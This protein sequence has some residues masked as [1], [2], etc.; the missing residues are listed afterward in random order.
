MGILALLAACAR[1]AALDVAVTTTVEASGLL[2]RLAPAFE[3]SVGVKLRAVVAGTGQALKLLEKGDVE[4]TLTHD[5]LAEEELA[6]RGVAQRMPVMW[7]EFIFVGPAADPAGVRGRPVEE[8][9]RA[10]A[11]GGHPF[12]SRGDDSGTHRLERKLWS[13]AGAEPARP[14]YR[15]TG[16]GMGE[17]LV[18][19]SQ[20]LAYTM[21]DSATLA[22]F[23]ARTGL[24]PLV[25]GDP[26]LVNH[27]GV[28]WRTPRGK[29]F[30]DWLRTP[31][32][33]AL[34]RPLFEPAP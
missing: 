8:A 19:A 7:N 11:T 1:P 13:A 28:L 16:Q 15:E 29:L 34:M 14:A 6:R 24:V 23:Q 9:L 27:Y 31:E 3:R 10:I 5:P 25:R 22:T 30:A 26:R 32:A 33:H 4:A 18:I 2:Q 20:L 17:T 12:V 21:V